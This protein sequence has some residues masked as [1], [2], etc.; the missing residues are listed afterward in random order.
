MNRC[1][2]VPCMFDNDCSTGLY[3]YENRFCLSANTKSLISKPSCNVSDIFSYRNVITKFSEEVPSVNRCAGAVCEQ[4]VDCY[5]GGSC[6][7]GLCGTDQ[8]P[9]TT[10]VAGIIGVSILSTIIGAVLGYAFF[11]T[12]NKP[13][14]KLTDDDPLKRHYIDANLNKSEITVATDDNEKHDEEHE[15]TARRLQY[16][17]V[18]E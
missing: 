11:K 6:T 10:G 17:N 7:N 18:K 15:D 13:I 12:I 4:N 3:C 1:E 9:P 8:V 14:T 5:Q 16:R 2:Y